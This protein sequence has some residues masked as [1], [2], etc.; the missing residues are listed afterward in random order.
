MLVIGGD[1]MVD[2]R[3]LASDVLAYNL[4]RLQVKELTPLETILVF[5]L[6]RCARRR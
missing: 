4:D 3:A 1:E 5:T 6:L 2:V